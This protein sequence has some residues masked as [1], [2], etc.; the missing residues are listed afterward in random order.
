MDY[1]VLGIT[2]NQYNFLMALSGSF[3]G[4]SVFYFMLHAF[5]YSGRK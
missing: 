4:W 3:F 2:L 1:E 5:Q